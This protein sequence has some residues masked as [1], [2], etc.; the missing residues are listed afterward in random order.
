MNT[1]PRSKINALQLFVMLFLS[2]I[3]II[4]TVNSQSVGE[5][6]FLD[7]ILSSFLLMLT[8][9]LLVIPL[10]ILNRT[11]PEHSIPSLAIENSGVF[12]K[13]IAV[14]YVVYF[15]LNNIVSLSLFLTLVINTANPTASRWSIAAIL[16]LIAAFGAEKG[17]ETVS[18][19]SIC[20][21]FLLMLGFLAIFTA[22]APRV[23]TRYMEPIL[24]DGVSHLIRGFVYFFSRCSSLAEIAI[25]MPYVL[26]RKR[27][28]FTVW[29]VGVPLLFGVLLFFTVTCLGEYAYLQVF[30]VY[31]LSTLAEIIGIQRLDA[32]LIGLSMMTLVIRLSCGFL[33]VRN[34]WP[35]PGHKLFSGT[36][37]L[38]AVA[39]ITA[40]AALWI[41]N[42]SERTGILFK[43]GYLLIFTGLVSFVIPVC[44]LISDKI[45][46]RSV[47]A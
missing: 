16:I 3:A 25:F 1:N 36:G 18:R 15:V 44:V 17:I 27:I 12:G 8:L 30:P 7:H 13:L 6:N 22:L 29:N 35:F 39:G 19:A 4:F 37:L 20:V 11:H 28:G 46:K 33:A 2:R 24:T 41:T 21:F 47:K 9:F 5:E 14:L 10:E 42:S 45:K 40:T 26:G 34:C 32:L 43:S 38:A 23:E 31:T